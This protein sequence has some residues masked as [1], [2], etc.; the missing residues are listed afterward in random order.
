MK[1]ESQPERNN[2]EK[3]HEKAQRAQELPGPFHAPP[4]GAALGGS[5]ES[6]KSPSESSAA[7]AE[8]AAGKFDAELKA[9]SEAVTRE[10]VA[11]KNLDALIKNGALPELIEEADEVWHVALEQV[12]VT[13]EN[14][15]T[16][17]DLWLSIQLARSLL[18]RHPKERATVGL[19][20]ALA[21]VTV[22]TQRQM[23]TDYPPEQCAAS[24]QSLLI[25]WENWEHS[26]REYSEA[27]GGNNLPARTQKRA[28]I[29]HFRRLMREVLY[30]WFCAEE[31]RAIRRAVRRGV[32]REILC[33]LY[34]FEQ[35][36][37]LLSW[38]G[39]VEVE[40]IRAAA[41]ERTRAGEFRTVP[42]TAFV[43]PPKWL[44][45]R[46]TLEAGELL[47][48]VDDEKTDVGTWDGSEVEA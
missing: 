15:P 19:G 37:K 4:Q 5:S 44:F 10:V 32:S 33:A 29:T 28:E 39:I 45:D 11:G 26:E 40:E 21:G 12:Q 7:L 46:A 16:V 41:E 47:E 1:A 24:A 43:P 8:L 38:K 6:D 13:Y 34:D 17:G 36:A 20:R 31:T 18:P 42:F 25:V 14:L 27:C 3:S 23:V 2:S 30:L 9:W 22:E 48:P 35:Y